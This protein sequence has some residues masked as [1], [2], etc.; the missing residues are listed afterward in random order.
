MTKKEDAETVYYQYVDLY[1]KEYFAGKKI[2][3]AL[4]P[5]LDI[6]MK[7]LSKAYLGFL[8]FRGAMIEIVN[9]NPY[10]KQLS[11][12]TISEIKILIEFVDAICNIMEDIF[13][14]VY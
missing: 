12:K 2:K 4:M 11:S 10:T 1:Y 8:L 9:D 14:C 7:R 13:D 6:E 5:T 3:D